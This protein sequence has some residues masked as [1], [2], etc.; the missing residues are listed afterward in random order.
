M[1]FKEPQLTAMAKAQRIM[2]LG[3]V[4]RLENYQLSKIVLSRKTIGKKKKERLWRRW[5]NN[6][7][8]D[9]KR[10]NIKI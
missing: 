8:G 2:Q 6:F 9:L 1:L 5:L 4:Q 3:H 10:I 7:E